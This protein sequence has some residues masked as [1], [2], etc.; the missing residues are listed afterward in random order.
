MVRVLKL[1]AEKLST[2]QRQ[3]FVTQPTS[4]KCSCAGKK[5]LSNTEIAF[6]TKL[7]LRLIEEYQNLIDQYAKQHPSWECNGEPWLDDFINQLEKNS[8]L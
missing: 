6:A 7:S 5:G 3:C 4:S 2:A 8:K 1:F